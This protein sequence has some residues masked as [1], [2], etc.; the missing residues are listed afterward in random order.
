MEEGNAP[1]DN[2]KNET[3]SRTR[4]KGTGFSIPTP[5]ISVQRMTRR[6]LLISQQT[7]EEE[8]RASEN[9]RFK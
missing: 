1:G 2:V 3:K 7:R 6:L 9:G 4:R 5:T 8:V